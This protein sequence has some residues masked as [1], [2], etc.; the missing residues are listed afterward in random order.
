MGNVAQGHDHALFHAF[1]ATHIEKCV[2]VFQQSSDIGG[3]VA[4]S[5][6]DIALGFAGFTRERKL[7]VNEV[8]GQVV[9]WTKVRQFSRRACTKKQHQLAAFEFAAGP[10]T[11]TPFGHRAH[12]RTARTGADH[13]DVALGVVGHQEAGAKR[14]DHL[15]F[16]THFQV[17]HVVRAHAPHRLAIVVFKHPLDGERQVVVARPLAVARA[18]NGVLAS[19]VRLALGVFTRWQDADRLALQHRERQVAKIEHDV[20]RVVIVL[21]GLLANF[22]HAQVARHGGGD[23]FLSGF[24]AV[25]VGVSVGRR[26]RGNRRAVMD[27][28]ETRGRRSAGGR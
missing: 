17:A 27:R 26:P 23:G 9:Q 1:E 24:G 20:V 2:A 10:Q 22:G 8:F 28:V 12:R 5:V 19:V 25:E 16:V 4:Q 11:T 3:A 6:L 15:H 7:D 21:T 18:G 14:P 13:H